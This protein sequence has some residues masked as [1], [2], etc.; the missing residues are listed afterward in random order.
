MVQYITYTGIAQLVEH[1]S[2]KPGVGSSSLSARAKIYL[3]SAVLAVFILPLLFY[4]ILVYSSYAMD[5][6]FFIIFY[7]LIFSPVFM[8]TVLLATFVLGGFLITIFEYFRVKSL[9]N[10]EILQNK[11]KSHRRALNIFA[12]IFLFISIVT[13][14]IS[15]NSINFAMGGTWLGGLIVTPFAYV[16]IYNLSFII[17]AKLKDIRLKLQELEMLKR[18]NRF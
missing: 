11:I 4:C 1:R 2:P 12:G 7:S 15:L 10:P 14:F 9:E 13:V 18:S 17:F 16:I 6:D 5:I 3:F 8:F